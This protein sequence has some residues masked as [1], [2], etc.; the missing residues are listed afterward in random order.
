[1]IK[2][3]L[4]TIMLL[5]PFQAFSEEPQQQR[6]LTAKKDEIFARIKQA[7]SGIQTLAGEFTQEKH[8][9]ILEKVSL[10]KGKF[11]Y[12]NP[13]SLRWEVTEPV[14]MGFIV[15]G[16]KG[17]KWRGKDGARL[18]F[19]LKKEPVIKIITDQI[20][21][22][23]RADFAWLEAGYAITVQ[24]ETPVTLDLVPLS[25][26][27]KKYIDHIRLIFSITEDYVSVIEIHEAGGDY[28]EIKFINMT[29][30]NPIQEDVF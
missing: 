8:L 1:M 29:I 28:T 9:E 7:A 5:M 18:S 22:W 30:N 4:M 11:F 25:A 21:A 3:I 14:A 17:K 13:D 2:Y 23:T 20:F 19:S 16:D 10:S 27:E 26:T 24:E 15:K 6:D 12:K